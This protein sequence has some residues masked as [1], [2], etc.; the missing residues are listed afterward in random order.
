MFKVERRGQVIR[1]QKD[2]ITIWLV[3]GEAEKLLADLTTVLPTDW[4]LGP[5]EPHPAG[6]N[7]VVDTKHWR[8]YD[9]DIYQEQ[10]P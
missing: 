3:P 8:A 6:R 5:D 1:L 9:Y 10:V 7:G 4:T 2:G